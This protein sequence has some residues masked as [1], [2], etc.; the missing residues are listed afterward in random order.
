MRPPAQRGDLSRRRCTPTSRVKNTDIQHLDAFEG[1]QR[2]HLG[3]R[4]RAVDADAQ[5]FVQLAAQAVQRRLAGIRL[6]AGEIEDLRR[7]AL[8]D[9]Q[10]PRA[11]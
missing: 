8:A 9:Q 2:A 4:A 10:Q 7:R 5:L 11:S 1:G 3:E 6:A